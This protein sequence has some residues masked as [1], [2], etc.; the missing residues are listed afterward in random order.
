MRRTRQAVYAGPAFHVL[1]L[2]LP[3]LRLK[4]GSERPA[5][6][7]LAGERLVD[8]T[9]ALAARIRGGLD[10]AGGEVPGDH[11]H[12]APL[13]VRQLEGVAHGLKLKDLAV[14]QSALLIVDFIRQVL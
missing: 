4:G 8:E 2:D 9:R 10:L 14:A 11:L 3:N 12:V 6:E 13:T 7:R 5:A 1:V